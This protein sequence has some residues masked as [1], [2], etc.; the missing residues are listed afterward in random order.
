MNS[1]FDEIHG[2]KMKYQWKDWLMV[3]LVDEMTSWWNDQMMK[4][5][6][7]EMTSWWND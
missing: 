2:W 4:W 7:D 5:L 3:W 6:V 1:P